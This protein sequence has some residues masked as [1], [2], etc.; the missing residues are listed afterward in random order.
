MTFN[1]VPTELVNELCKSLDRIEEAIRA[2]ERAK[3]GQDGRG[4][5]VA[6]SSEARAVVSDHRHARPPTAGNRSAA[7]DL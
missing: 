5:S 1:N 2:D 6:S 7:E 3:I 4:F